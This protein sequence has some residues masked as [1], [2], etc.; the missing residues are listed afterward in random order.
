MTFEDSNHYGEFDII[1][2]FFN[3]EGWNPNSSST[4]TIQNSLVI[5]SIGDDCALLDSLSNGEVLAITSDMLVENHHFFKDADPKLLGHKCLAVNLSDLAAIGAQ[6]I[7]F[8][9]CISLPEIKHTWLE[10]FAAGLHHISD[11][12]GCTLIGGDTTAGP[13]NIA[14]TAY[15]SVPK[16]LALRR[17]A[18]KVS[19]DIWVS[20]TVGDARCI[21]GIRRGEWQLNSSWKDYAWRM[22]APIPRVE[23]GR[24]LLGI[25]NAAIDIS[26]GLLGDLMHILKASKVSAQIWLDEVPHS[27]L[28]ENVSLELR[29]L[30]TLRGGDDYELCF[31]APQNQREAIIALGEELRLP[32]TRIGEIKELKSDEIITLVDKDHHPVP[33]DLVSHYLHSF[34]HFAPPV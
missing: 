3:R 6:P 4:K 2:K 7:A 16:N 25:A 9:L 29:R 28:L 5:E 14:I 20:N 18:A 15:G 24:R 26:D 32:L 8:S 13:L 30:C 17:S 27:H 19:D 21:L 23:L 31:T 1:R 22:D 34:D 12:Y 10:L 11:Q 33:A